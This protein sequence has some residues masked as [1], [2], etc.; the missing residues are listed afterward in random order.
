M[1][2]ALMGMLD[3]VLDDTASA[4]EAA[5]LRV[6]SL[7]AQPSPTA[8]LPA[9]EVIVALATAARRAETTWQAKYWDRVLQPAVRNYCLSEAL[10]VEQIPDPTG[11][12]HRWAGIDAAIKG[13]WYAVG[14]FIGLQDKLS[15]FERSEWARE[16]WWMAN[17]SLLMQMIDDW[18]DQDEDRG[19]RLTPVVTGNWTLE[20]AADLFQKTVQDLNVLL[21]ANGIQKPLLKAIIVDLYVDYLHTAIDAMRTGMAA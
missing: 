3:V 6:A 9:E 5:A 12:G 8:L 20:T 11:M 15:R 13:M 4:G 10:A 19:T 7:T 18:V 1:I 16:Q 2:S 14:P 21:D 17:T